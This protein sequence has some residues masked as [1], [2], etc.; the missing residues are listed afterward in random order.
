MC[1][2]T[3]RACAISSSAPSAR[4]TLASRCP[5]PSRIISRSR[6]APRILAHTPTR[7]SRSR[8]IT[9]DWPACAIKCGAS[10]AG[11]ASKRATS[12]SCCP[13]FSAKNSRAASKH[14][15]MVCP[16]R[17]AP[18]TASC[19]LWT[20]QAASSPKRFHPSWA[21]RRSSASR[22]CLSE[23]ERLLVST[24]DP[25]LLLP[26]SYFELWGPDE[27]SKKV[28]DLV[29]AFAQFPRLPRLL[30]PRALR[31]TLVRGVQEGKFVLRLV[32]DDGSTRTFW[33]IPPDEDTLARPQLE[34]LP[35]HAAELAN[36]EPE[37]LIPGA[38]P[39]LW[40]ASGDPVR[41][42]SLR[43]FFDGKRAPRLHSPDV[44]DAAIRAAVQRGSLMARQEVKTYLREPL[45]A[46]NVADDLEL[47]T[48]PP[49]VRGADLG[50]KGLP[51]AWHAGKASLARCGRRA[52]QAA[53]L[54]RAVG[55]LARWRERGALGAPV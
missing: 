8:P 32:R 45:P 42:A 6:P 37:L 41:V 20:K 35:A 40:P 1:P 15:R 36:L 21:S 53:R 10:S 14:R 30:R 19:W 52:C 22:S 31:D 17:F 33:M 50:P 48:P 27:K 51:E 54:C 25:E 5:K 13:T 26:G 46:G 47:L 16:M 28:K 12:S 34:V 29:S 11:A 18:P 24:L 7:W 43:T 23:S 55:A 49:A 3:S 9:L 4:L 39:E 38:V 2:I 44:L